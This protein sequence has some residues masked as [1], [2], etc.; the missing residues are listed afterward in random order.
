MWVN[1][2]NFHKEN[3][4]E[5]PSTSQLDQDIQAFSKE[6]MDRL[7]AFLNS[8][9]K[10]LCS[11]GLTM[12]GQEALKD[13]NWVRAMKEE[14]KAL[15]KNSTW[16]IV[17]RPK[18]KGAVSCRWIYTVK[19]KFDRTQTY[20]IDYEETFIPV[21][22]INT[23]RVIISLVA[24]FGWNL[25]Q[26]DVKNVFLHGDLEEVYIEIF[27]GF[28]SHNEKTRQIQGDHTLFIKHSPNG[29]LTILL[30]YANDLKEKL[31]TQFEMKELGKQKYFLGIEVAYFKQGIFTHKGSMYS[32]SSKKQENWDTRPRGSRILSHG[33]G[34]CEG[35][36]MKII[37]NDLKVKY[38][39]PIKLFCDNNSAISIA[40]NPVKHDRTKHTEIDRHFIKEKLDNGLIVTAHVPTGLQV[41]DVFTKGLRANRF[42]EFNG[43]LGMIYIHLPT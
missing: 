31:A 34:I 2:T 10:S 14:T 27:P 25:Q 35:L 5:H 28:Y 22:K 36:W 42:Q 24:H 17:D 3:V 11:C 29:K 20:G 21:T 26:F 18:D 23:I 8:T 4:V 9:R 37:L 30:V 1:Q 33:Q 7:R 13:E 16:E 32:I 19:C 41:A 43:K 15:E 6:E 40:H 12:N 38:E 39:G